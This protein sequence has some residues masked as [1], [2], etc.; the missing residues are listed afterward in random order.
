MIAVVNLIFKGLESG[1]WCEIVAFLAR[2]QP[3]APDRLKKLMWTGTAKN[4]SLRVQ[5]KGQSS[6]SRNYDKT[7]QTKLQGGARR[8][9]RVAALEAGLCP[10]GGQAITRPPQPQGR[11]RAPKGQNG[12]LQATLAHGLR[13]GGKSGNP[14]LLHEGRPPPMFPTL[15]K[16]ALDLFCPIICAPPKTPP[17]KNTYLT[18]TPSTCVFIH[19]YAGFAKEIFCA[20]WTVEIPPLVP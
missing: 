18:R 5:S 13:N 8:L 20:P 3:Y 12:I 9:A 6:E 7:S 11:C 19:I 16:P 2:G 10:D 1:V 15:S 17:V 14:P 4:S